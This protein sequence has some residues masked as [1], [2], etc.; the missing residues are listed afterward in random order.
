[1][2]DA[3]NKSAYV[4]ETDLYAPLNA[5][6]AELGVSPM[7][8]DFDRQWSQ[9]TNETFNKLWANA[10]SE[11]AQDVQN[12]FYKDFGNRELS[13]YGQV[14]FRHAYLLVRL[15][16]DI[17]NYPDETISDGSD[18][19]A[20]SV[21]F[22]AGVHYGRREVDFWALYLQLRTAVQKAKPVLFEPPADD[23]TPAQRA[24]VTAWDRMDALYA[25]YYLPTWRPDF[26]AS[27]FEEP[28]PFDDG[29]FK[30]AWEW[31]DD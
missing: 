10:D 18:I 4:R 11:V 27:G 28:E 19:A 31:S 13:D 26:G 12:L 29:L 16:D 24:A 3:A 15:L 7:Q 21:M 8:N 23:A 5:A 2:T 20:C 6:W 22:Y 25:H 17:E 14:L 9:A 30:D 1:M